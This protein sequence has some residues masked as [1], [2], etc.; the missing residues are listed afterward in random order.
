MRSAPEKKI[1]GEEQCLVVGASVIDTDAHL[2][3]SMHTV[4]DGSPSI[5]GN[6]LPLFLKCQAA[7]GWKFVV[8][9]AKSSAQLIPQMLNCDKCGKHAGH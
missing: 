1:E 4:D 5:L 7:D 8:S 9:K 2:A 3:S 6:V